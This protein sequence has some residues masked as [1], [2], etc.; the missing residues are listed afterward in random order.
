LIPLP[1]AIRCRRCGWTSNSTR[2]L[3]TAL[4]ENGHQVRDFVVRRLLKELGYS[5][6]S[7][8]K[9]TKGPQ[10]PDGDVQFQY[11]NGQADQHLDAGNPVISVDTKKKV[12]VGPFKNGGRELSPTGQPQTG[13]RQDTPGS[14]ITG[15]TVVP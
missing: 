3:A 15:R 7:N 13:R 12:L 6:Q 1:V 11:L 8:A 10:H 14:P 4:T 2:K 9:T 5:L